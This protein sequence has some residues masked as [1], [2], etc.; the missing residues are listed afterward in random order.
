M[1]HCDNVGVCYNVDEIKFKAYSTEHSHVID[2][3]L[4]LREVR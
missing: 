1:L 2:K 4:H 3:L